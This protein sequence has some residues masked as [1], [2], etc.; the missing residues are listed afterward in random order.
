MHVLLND[1]GLI[2]VAVCGTGC[3]LRLAWADIQQGTLHV[4]CV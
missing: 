2:C 1:Y 4:P 3:Q